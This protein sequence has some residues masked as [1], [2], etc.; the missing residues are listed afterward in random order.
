MNWY[1][2]VGNRPVRFVD[3]LGLAESDDDERSL[4]EKIRGPSLIAG[5]GAVL[6]AVRDAGKKAG[7]A[8]SMQA[9][10]YAK[11]G[12]YLLAVVGGFL[13]YQ[14]TRGKADHSIDLTTDRINDPMGIPDDDIWE[15]L[16]SEGLGCP[17]DNYTGY[18]SDELDQ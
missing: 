12:G 18:G 5:G 7:T 2:Y 9:R 14:D 13:T 4:W 8:L 16:E 6:L 3:P 11:A 15:F 10:T 17:A 1:A